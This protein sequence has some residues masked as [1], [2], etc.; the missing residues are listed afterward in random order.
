MFC[1]N[2]GHEIEPD[3]LYCQNCGA[4]IADQIADSQA[5]EETRQPIVAGDGFAS[6]AMS[7]DAETKKTRKP[8]AKKS[9]SKVLTEDADTA[10]LWSAVNNV[11]HNEDYE[12]QEGAAPARHSRATVHDGV[13]KIYRK[14][15]IEGV[16][17]KETGVFRYVISLKEYRDSWCSFERLLKDRDR[18][19]PQPCNFSGESTSIRNPEPEEMKDF[20][21]FQHTENVWFV[22][23]VGD[24]KSF[25]IDEGFTDAD[26][27]A[28]NKTLLEY[29][30]DPLPA[31]GTPVFYWSST[32][33]SSDPLSAKYVSLLSKTVGERSKYS[34]MNVRLFVK[35]RK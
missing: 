23:S 4:S 30:G 34:K 19:N 26:R 6:A 8:S 10:D 16:V 28:V 15:G 7:A 25:T 29:G 20:P 14:N 17:V 31:V 21:A 2:C 9:K 27:D 1:S 24:L 32:E 13:G 5:V 3:D 18:E 12:A 35:V 11:S 22:P 33:S